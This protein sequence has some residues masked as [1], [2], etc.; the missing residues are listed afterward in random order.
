M[1][2]VQRLLFGEFPRF[3]GNP[4]QFP[5]FDESSFDVFLN[6]NE[7]E[8]DCYSRISWMSRTRDWLC[9]RIFLDLDG[10]VS[11]NGLTDTE[12]VSLLQ[13]DRSFRQSVLGDVVDD[14]RAIAEL[15]FEESLPMVG[16]YTGKGVHIHLLC[17]PRK[18]PKRE[19]ES[20]QLWVDDVCGLSTFDRNV[21]GDVK[22]LSRVPNCRRYDE[23]LGDATSLYTVPL[24]RREMRNITAKELIEW[25]ESPRTVEDPGESRLPLFV[26]DDYVVSDDAEDVS[27]EAVEMG[28]RTI[29]SLDEKLELWLENVLQLPCMYK[30]ITTRNPAHPVR[31]NCAVMM[32]NVGM[33][34]DDIVEVYSRLG[35]ADFDANVTRRFAQQIKERGYADMSCAA[36]QAEGLCMYQQGKREEQCETFGYPG[37]V[38]KW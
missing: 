23:K 17:E 25:S 32:F 15:G 21:L 31:F 19:L 38:Q 2:P 33:T 11:R 34:V 8:N 3:V 36:I 10:N 24:S 9:D 18:W 28:K 20:N 26:R 22:R 7:G 4:S 35:W 1:D 16:V 13:T 14:V 37:G 29:D 30:R 6:K 12:I 27:V 5:V